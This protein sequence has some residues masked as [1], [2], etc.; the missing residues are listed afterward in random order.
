MCD[1]NIVAE[2]PVDEMACGNPLFYMP[3]RPVVRE[4]AVS[5]KVGPVFDASAKGYNGISLNDCMEIGP[6]LLTNLTQIV[7]RFRRGK[8]AH[9]VD[10]QKPFLQI[11]V[12]RDDCG[13]HR[14][15]WDCDGHVKVMRSRRVPFGNYS[16][17]V[18]LN[19]TVQHP[20]SLFPAS[21]TVIELQQNLYVDDFLSGC[22]FVEETCQMIHEA[23]DVMS[24][25]CMTLTKW[26]S[27]STEVADV[28]QREF[29]GKHLDDDSIKVLGLCWLASSACFM[30]HAAVPPEGL[31]LTKH[32]VLSWFSRLFNPLGLAAPY[33]MQAKCFFPGAVD[34]GFAVGW[35][36]SSWISDT[37]YEVGWCIVS[38]WE[39][40][41]NSS[42]MSLECSF[43]QVTGS[44]IKTCQCPTDDILLAQWV[45]DYWP[46]THCQTGQESMYFLSASG[47][48]CLFTTYGPFTGW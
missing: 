41:Y 42:Q 44:F 21:R 43:D 33:I 4:S 16:S 29:K 13:V 48:T 14:F 6:C 38:C 37:V 23:C 32:V 25:G 27:N 22:D 20:L 3:H 36:N 35:W 7:I 39:T 26:S 5:T 2:G 45:L 46:E 19:A 34:I 8:F 1:T 15:L 30:F 47:C 18:L 11:A 28:L 24:Q 31:C 12:H 40:S 9:T 10:I 17:P